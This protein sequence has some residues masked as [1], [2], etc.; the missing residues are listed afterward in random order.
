M[1]VPQSSTL[2]VREHNRSCLLSSVRL[3]NTGESRFP[4]MLHEQTFQMAPSVGSCLIMVCM[5]GNND[6]LAIFSHLLYLGESEA[7][8]KKSAFLP[9]KGKSQLLPFID[10]S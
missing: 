9:H 1:A 4:V 5:Y 10:K 6:L 7:N 2:W 3:K 8:G